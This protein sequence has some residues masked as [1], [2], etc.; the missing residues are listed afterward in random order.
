MSEKKNPVSKAQTELVSR[1]F[2]AT[3][4]QNSSY[5]E[6]V[7]G[8]RHLSCRGSG[9]SFSLLLK[10]K[11]AMIW[12]KKLS[13]PKRI[14]WKASATN[15]KLE[16]ASMLCILRM[17]ELLPLPPVMQRRKHTNNSL[18][19]SYFLS[20]R[21]MLMSWTWYFP[22]YFPVGPSQKKFHTCSKTGAASL[23]PSFFSA[24][25]AP[26]ALDANN[27]AREQNTKIKTVS[28]CFKSQQEV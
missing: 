8:D 6:T 22:R 5:I 12:D 27:P 9:E 10:R 23:L 17:A 15:W 11:V 18:V 3:G 28:K 14:L 24:P 2:Y 13:D 4:G 16:P 19:P 21:A 7:P 1:V 25:S 20:G 26:T